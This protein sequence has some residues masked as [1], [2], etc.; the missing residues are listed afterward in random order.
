M[1][2]RNYCSCHN[3]YSKEQARYSYIL[4]LRGRARSQFCA[5]A[6]H[7]FQVFPYMCS[8]VISACGRGLYT[9]TFNGAVMARED[10]AKTNMFNATSVAFEVVATLRITRASCYHTRSFA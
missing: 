1:R 9:S 4:C 5:V 7:T 2:L 8:A 3:Q 10:Q 6:C